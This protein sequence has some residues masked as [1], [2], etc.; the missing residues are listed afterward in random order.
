M[1]NKVLFVDDEQAVLDGFKRMLHRDFEIDTEC[2]G[3]L[4]LKAIHSRG[5]YAV[6]VSDMR[7][8]QMDGVQ[9]LSKVRQITPDTVRLVLT[10]HADIQS[11]MD[12]VNQGYL[13][14]FLAKPCDKDTLSKALTAALVQHRL[15]TA[16]KELLENTF[17]G[18][19][20]VLTDVLGLANP[21]AFGRAM[22]IR[23]YVQQIVKTLALESPWRFEAAAMLSQLGC[24]TLDPD[25]IESAYYGRKLSAEEQAKFDAHP[26]VA[27]NLLRNIPRLEPIAWMIGEQAGSKREQGAN[28]MQESIVT[29]AA[30]LRLALRYDNLRIQGMSKTEAIA[31]LRRKADFEPRLLNALGDLDSGSAMMEKKLT[32]VSELRSGMVLEEEIRTNTGLL[33]VARGQE[34]SYTLL[35]RLK[36]FSHNRAI[37]ENVLVLVPVERIAAAAH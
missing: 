35:A 10:G 14:R 36:N 16:E 19:I 20:K 12:A 25:T 6:V 15:I 7:M 9:F 23:G 24:V 31:D 8:P 2:G 29:G 18:S 34:I 22:R 4:A 27:M 32:P 28:Q 37:P 11:A 21:A 17:M 30:I 33:I 5:P 13:F 26:E 1:N 3:E